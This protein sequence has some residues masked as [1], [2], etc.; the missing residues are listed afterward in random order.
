MEFNRSVTVD[1]NEVQEKSTMTITLTRV[2]KKTEYRDKKIAIEPQQWLIWCESEL[3]LK[4]LQRIL[5]SMMIKRETTATK[6]KNHIL[7]VERKILT[8]HQTLLSFHFCWWRNLC[9]LTF[10][11]CEW[12]W[13]KLMWSF[14]ELTGA[15]DYEVER[16]LQM[17]WWWWW[18]KMMMMILS[19]TTKKKTILSVLKDRFPR[20]NDDE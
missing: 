13:L 15:L 16:E 9:L 17:K 10:G 8:Q 1:V 19:I 2:T 20:W 5:I 11:N 12:S 3:F 6:L 7:N 18:E 14:D 4:Y